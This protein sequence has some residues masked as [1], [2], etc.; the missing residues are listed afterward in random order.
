[1][2]IAVPS[3]EKSASTIDMIVCV[4]LE[5]RSIIII[6]KRDVDGRQPSS[7][8]GGSSLRYTSGAQ[9]DG[10]GGSTKSAC[11]AGIDESSECE[12]GEGRGQHNLQAKMLPSALDVSAYIYPTLRPRPELLDGPQ[13]PLF[14][15]RTVLH[16]KR[17]PML[18]LCGMQHSFFAALNTL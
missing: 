15:V 2:N 4:L 16:I 5:I 9:A 12:R 7:C 13:S 14:V 3:Y 8:E 11:W 6:R 18:M 17:S 10:L 1:M